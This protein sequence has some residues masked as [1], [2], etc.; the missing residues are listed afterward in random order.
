MSLSG[1]YLGNPMRS[2]LNRL[3]VDI[4]IDCKSITHEKEL[5]ASIDV[6]RFDLFFKEKNREDKFASKFVPQQATF[7]SSCHS[8]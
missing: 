5:L 3:L 4:M 8:R 1:D 7:R 2:K 6:F